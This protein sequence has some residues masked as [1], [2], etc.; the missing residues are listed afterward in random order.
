MGY[1][2]TILGTATIILASAATINWLIDPAGIFRETT[3]GQQ[4]ANALLNSE[5]GL[6]TPNSI[7]ERE[8]KSELA[9]HSAR[10]DCVVIGSSHVMQ[11]GSARK[12]RSFPTCAN[13]LNLGVS[14]ASIEDHIVLSWLTLSSG[15]PRVLI[16]GVDPWTLAFGKDERWKVRY[17]DQYAIACM[18]FEGKMSA[19][20]VEPPSR[21]SSLINAEYTKRSLWSLLQGT[22]SPSVVF[23]PSV[24]EDVGNLSAITLPDGS[25]VY[26]AEYIATSKA[27]SVPLGGDNYKTKGITNELS[28]IELYRRM[29]IWAKERKVTPVL[30]MTP[31]HHNVWMVNATPN[32]KAMEET[33]RIVK[34]IGSALNV[35]VVGSFRPDLVGCTPEQFYDFMHPM[36]SCL[37]K[38]TA[39]VLF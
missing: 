7:D 33:E 27:S 30:L 9:K 10:Y 2:L 16:L 11:V 15:Q 6:I 17:P 38:F 20:N 29:I 25:H 26:S 28:A 24:D 14:G 21:W 8:I 35:L 31:Y 3:F 19:I 37:A 18:A 4:Y 32:V 39:D 23:A 5:N 1:L 22:A 36:A 12:Y 13:I 34:E